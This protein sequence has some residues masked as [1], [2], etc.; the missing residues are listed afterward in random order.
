MASKSNSP[1]IQPLILPTAFVASKIDGS[2][3]Q[4][5]RPLAYLDER[6]IRSRESTLF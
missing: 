3:R 4:M 2:G 5:F 1:E 6:N